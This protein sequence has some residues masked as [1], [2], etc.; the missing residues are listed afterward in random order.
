MRSWCSRQTGAIRLTVLVGLARVVAVVNP[1][2]RHG[3]DRE[4]DGLDPPLSRVPGLALATL[5]LGA[6]LVAGCARETLVLSF[7]IPPDAP[8]AS[9]PPRVGTSYEKAVRAI[10]GIMVRDLEL[11]LSGPLTVLVYPTRA[12]YAGGL[13]STGGIPPGRA[14]EIAAYAVAVTQH[15]RLFIND[16]ELRDKPRSVWLGILTHE[17]AHHAQ[18]QLSGG[19]RGRSEQWLRE[20]MAD[21]IA[22]R[23]LDRLG[24][25]TFRRERAR[26]LHDVAGAWRELGPES[27]DL[28]EL[29]RPQGWEARHLRPDG[30]L[31]YRLA[32]LLA[33]ELI[34]EHGWHSVL[35]YFRA[36]ARS[37]DRFSNFERAFGE[38]LEDFAA[39]APVRLRRDIGRLEG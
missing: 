16:E 11:P 4:R 9:E 6:A 14:A 36:F 13:V 7:W 38:S 33:D 15:G 20:G 17:L 30:Q 34:R 24:E 23:V 39:D 19:H 27:L 28:A 22:C 18:Y 3:R 1:G 21:W 35:D 37:D 32:F 29:G 10:T 8:P 26:A 2:R 31:I 5:V 25:T 12:A